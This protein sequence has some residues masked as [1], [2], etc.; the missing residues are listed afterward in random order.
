MKA[1]RPIAAVL[2]LAGIGLLAWVLVTLTWGEPF[3][4]VSQARA[5][6]ALSGELESESDRLPGA[7]AVAPTRPQSGHA[8]G[9]L[10]IPRL[11]LSTVVVE[12]T[13]ADD[14]A[15]GPGHYAS[16]ALPGSG[17][18]VAIAGHRTTYGAPFRH[19]DDL[20]PGDSIEA[21]MPYGTYRYVVY[22]TRIVDDRNWSILR[23]RTFEKLVLT[24]CHPLYSAEQRYVVFARLQTG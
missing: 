1:A 12:G 6:A 7:P 16:T 10:V 20:R 21:Q 19:I 22:A 14:L 4:A 24:A 2:A 9:R 18:V 5:Q 11:D 13:S 17:R 15:R 3:T 8:L 23:P